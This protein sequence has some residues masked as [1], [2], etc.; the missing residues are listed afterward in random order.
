MSVTFGAPLLYSN[1]IISAH[2]I[3][4][5]DCSGIPKATQPLAFALIFRVTN[6]TPDL[7]SKD[8]SNE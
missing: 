6:S 1:N 4:P 5:E 2:G 8:Q 7:V 3:D